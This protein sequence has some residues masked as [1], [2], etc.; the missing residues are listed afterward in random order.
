MG[1]PEAAD[2]S[3]FW[4]TE[5]MT[6]VWPKMTFTGGKLAVLSPGADL[7]LGLVVI[8]VW[9]MESRTGPLLIKCTQE[10]KL[11]SDEEIKLAGDLYPIWRVS[12]F[13]SWPCRRASWNSTSTSVLLF[14]VEIREN[15][16]IVSLIVEHCSK[17]G[18]WRGLSGGPGAEWPIPVAY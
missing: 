3:I 14:P 9:T 10:A 2:F 5:R 8:V 18:H 15:G 4:R 1:T 13:E 17:S 11:F 12:I 6:A 16:K 7:E